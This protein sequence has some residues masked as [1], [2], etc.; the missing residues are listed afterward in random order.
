M[1]YVLIISVMTKV[2]YLTNLKN[3]CTYIVQL[4]HDHSISNIHFC[5]NDSV[6]VTNYNVGFV[7]RQFTYI[8][9]ISNWLQ[10]S[11]LIIIF[12]WSLIFVIR[13]D[14]SHSFDQ[15][16][17]KFHIKLKYDHFISNIHIC[18]NEYMFVN[19]NS[20]GFV[21]RRRQHT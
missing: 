13:D 5:K 10:T 19:F 20:V 2:I 21:K 17:N 4:K 7:K 6:F 1:T 9:R 3:N 15:F 14:L 12:L 18:K 16:K 8:M 11:S